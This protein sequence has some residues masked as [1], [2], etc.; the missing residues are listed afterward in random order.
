MITR[1]DLIP[2]ATSG[3][4]IATLIATNSSNIGKLLGVAVAKTE[5][6]LEREKV[7]IFAR[8]SAILYGGYTRESSELGIVYFVESHPCVDYSIT[9]VMHNVVISQAD[10]QSSVCE[11]LPELITGTHTV[12]TIKID[13][14]LMRP[15]YY[16]INGQLIESNDV[17][18]L[19]QWKFNI[20]DGTFAYHTMT[21]AIPLEGI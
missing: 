6:E 11:D 1:R 10:R 4:A 20:S 19:I 16:T 21:V 18:V 8:K 15:H 5:A 17:N 3:L 9:Y 12:R 14:K 2:W 13:P 7:E